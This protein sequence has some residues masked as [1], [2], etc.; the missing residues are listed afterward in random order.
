MIALLESKTGADARKAIESS[1]VA[2]KNWSQ[3]TTGMERSRFLSRWSDL[4]KENSEDIT[5]IMSLESGKPLAESTAELNYGTSFIDFYAGEAL[6]PTNAG[7]GAIWPSP[8]SLA[9]GSPKGKIMAVQEAVGV[10]ALITPWNFPLA[11]ITRK[12]SPA[13]AAG[14]TVVLKPSE[15]TPLTAVALYQ[16]ALRAG[17][18]KNVFELV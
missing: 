6:R 18:P 14:C 3:K 16:L 15:L 2:F 7:G 17:L 5:K 11:M 10:C 9:D 12:A 13:L 8:F 1:S 4:I